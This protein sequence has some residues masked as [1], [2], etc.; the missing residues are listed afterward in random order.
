MK[1][2][3]IHISSKAKFFQFEF[4]EIAKYWDLLYLMVRR[5]FKAS[6]KQT[7]LG[8]FWFFA[9]PIITSF[10]YLLVFSKIIGVKTGNQDPTLFYM[11]GVI[12]WN[13]FSSCFT[14]N[15]NVL[16]SN[17]RLFSKVYFPR[18]IIPI[19]IIISS[20]GRF[21]IQLIFY[22]VFSYFQSP[23]HIPFGIY[24][25]V[26]IL[27]TSVLT[28]IFGTSIGLLVASITT[29]YRDFNHLTGFGLQLILF[30]TPILY[31][32]DSLSAEYKELLSINPLTNLINLF[33]SALLAHSEIAITSYTIFSMAI[34]IFLF[35]TSSLIYTRVTKNFIDRI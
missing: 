22:Y 21:A 6:Y 16:M 27:V 24:E 1:K 7:I 5:D 34:I 35:M 20:F 25:C 33:R 9:Q 13:L 23:E 17:A 26:L 2:K 30:A 10:V 14:I 8:P 18:I 29:K 32:F 4:T 28:S 31:S 12:F 19:S 15:S 3:E 11:S